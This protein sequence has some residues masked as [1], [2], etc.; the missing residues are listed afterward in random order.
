MKKRTVVFGVVL[1]L[2]LA[3]VAAV[4]LGYWQPD[5]AVAQAPRAAT[6]RS[7][8]VDLATATLKKVPVRIDLLG[9]VTPIAS[10]AVKTRLDSEITAVH[11]KD[12]ETVKQGAPL[13]TLDSRTIEAQIKQ[14]DG[15]LAGAKAQLEQAQRDVER[16]T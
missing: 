16:Y 7:I 3:A 14:I 4:K 8:P 12:G 10:V 11:F 2:V 15:L 9:T 13:F 1:A 6:P 5:G